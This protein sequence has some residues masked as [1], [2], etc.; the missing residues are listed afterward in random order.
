MCRRVAQLKDAGDL[1]CVPR[2]LDEK[3]VIDT[4]RSFM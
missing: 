4:F 2:R 3:S 1:F